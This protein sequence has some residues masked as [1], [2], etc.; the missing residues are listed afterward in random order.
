MPQ[1]RNRVYGIATLISGE[2]KREEIKT[3][4][5]DCVKSMQTNF[6]FPAQ[7]IFAA[8]PEEPPKRG[9]HAKLVE[10]AQEQLPGK[11]NIFVDCSASLTRVTHCEDAC[12]CLTPGHPVYSTLLRRYLGPEDHLNLQGFFRTAI[13]DESHSFLVANPSLCQD[14]CGNSFTS[15]AFQ[16][17]FLA[18]FAAAGS[19]W[20]TAGWV[21][22]GKTLSNSVSVSATVQ[23]RI[24]SKRPAP[25]YGEPRQ[26]PSL[27][28]NSQKARQ[29]VPKA[30]ARVQKRSK[31]QRKRRH[32]DG[33]KFSKGKKESATLWDK[34]QMTR[35]QF[36]QAR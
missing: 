5:I 23:R 27:K 9:R 10:M 14:L 31:Y 36:V 13:S 25:E 4:F 7:T 35:P 21:D 17:V 20:R 24:R 26:M 16:A 19:V 30:R 15:T 2:S 22:E 18:S 3:N 6:H 11:K 1:R 33:R 29:R 28:K 8:L 34:E 32:V 12:P